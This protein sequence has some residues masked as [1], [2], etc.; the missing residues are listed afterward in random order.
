MWSGLNASDLKG[1]QVGMLTLQG[2]SLEWGNG[3]GGFCLC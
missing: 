3:K 1:Q 2:N